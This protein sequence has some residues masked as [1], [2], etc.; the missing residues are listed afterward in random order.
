MV[1]ILPPKDM[2]HHIVDV[3]A[4]PEERQTK[5]NRSVQ[6]NGNVGLQP[7]TLHINAPRT[8][9]QFSNATNYIQIMLLFFSILAVVAVVAV[10]V[11]RWERSC[12]L[13][14]DFCFR[15]SHLYKFPSGYLLQMVEGGSTHDI[16]VFFFFVF[17]S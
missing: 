13:L 14:V 11:C 1:R 3:R 8:V 7:L 10:I 15:L 9:R 17:A 2:S 5:L 4:I 12:L 6:H 16:P